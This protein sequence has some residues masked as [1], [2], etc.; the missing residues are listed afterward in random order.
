MKVIKHYVT[1]Y[2]PGSFMPETDTVEF[3][4][5]DLKAIA[6]KAKTL[7]QRY[8]AKPFG[9]RVETKEYEEIITKD[10]KVFRTKTETT[11]SSGIYF[12]TGRVLTL[13]DVPDTQENRIL[14]SNMEGNKKVCVENT[15]S[16]R[17]TSFFNQEDK[18]IDWDGNVIAEGKNY[19]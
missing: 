2:S 1:F 8:G 12:L 18:I 6:A 11:Y 3:P 5:I 16:Y 9:F 14:R 7:S 17:H 15:N 10:D 19:Y 4:S 13:N